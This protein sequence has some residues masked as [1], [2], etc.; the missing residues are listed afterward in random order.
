MG[1]ELDN[2]KIGFMDTG[3]IYAEGFQGIQSDTHA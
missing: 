2:V 3:T 1:Y